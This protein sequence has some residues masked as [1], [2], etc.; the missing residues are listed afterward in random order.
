MPKLIRRAIS[1]WIASLFLLFELMVSQ[2][3]AWEIVE[4]RYFHDGPAACKYG[5][6]PP[7]VHVL[8][9]GVGKAP[10]AQCFTNGFQTIPPH[11]KNIGACFIEVK[12]EREYNIWR[13]RETQVVKVIR[14]K[15]HCRFRG[16]GAILGQSRGIRKTGSMVYFQGEGPKN[17]TTKD[18]DCEIIFDELSRTNENFIR[19]IRGR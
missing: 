4:L 1:F 13:K 18:P 19:L 6:D 17:F 10:V 9:M 3:A 7:R 12:A 15:Y 8:P 2:A 16:A 11:T 14:R 5:Y